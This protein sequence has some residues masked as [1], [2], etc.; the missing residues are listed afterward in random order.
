MLVEQRLDDA[1]ISEDLGLYQ[2]L[3]PEGEL[4]EDVEDRIDRNLMTTMYRQMVTARVFDRK[5]INLQRQGRLGTYPPF[6]G[7]EAAQIGSALAMDAADWM[8]PTYRD[9]GAGMCRGL[10]MSSVLL[11][12]MGRM[13]GGTGLKALRLLPPSV[14]IATHLLHAVGTS[15]ATKLQHEHVATIAYFGDGASSEGDFHEALNFAG[16]YK[17]PM[18][19]V[20]QNNGF[21]ISVPFAQQSASR[22]ISQRAIAYDIEGVRVDG[23]DVFAVW[24]VVSQARARA[25]RG[26]GPTLIEAV[27]FRY[28]AHTTA[29]DPKRY[30]EEE[31]ATD[32][33]EHRDPI[34]RLKRFLERQSLWNEQLEGE[35]MEAANERIEEALVEVAAHKTAHPE[36]MFE[37]VYETMPWHV[38]EQQQEFTHIMHRDGVNE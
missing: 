7:Q 9:H 10:K 20:C 28:G 32:W 2:I 17:L 31:L 3:T 11:Y 35:L 4:L 16:L 6:E 25:L 37:H 8:F 36:E 14:P 13:E 34:R 5:A 15:W 29:D 18:V 33:R 30:R 27:T 24:S 21:A 1:R 26:E 19:F 12:W 23:N 22:T 38:K